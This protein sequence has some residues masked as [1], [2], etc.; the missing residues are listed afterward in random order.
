MGRT[1][2]RYAR[3]VGWAHACGFWCVAGNYLDFIKE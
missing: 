2:N 1:K 3:L